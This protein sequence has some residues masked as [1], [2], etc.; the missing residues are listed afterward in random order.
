MFPLAG[1]A[2][3]VALL[4]DHVL[5]SVD[6]VHEPAFRDVVRKNTEAVPRLH[7]IALETAE[8][9]SSRAPHEALV[10]ASSDGA[11][12]LEIA[13]DESLLKRLQELL[14]SVENLRKRAGEES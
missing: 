8:M 2:L 7:C 10:G 12:G 11:I 4:P 1:N 13:N 3:D 9:E 5:V 6:N 14:Y